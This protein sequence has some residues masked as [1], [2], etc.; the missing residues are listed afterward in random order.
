MGILAPVPIGILM[1]GRRLRWAAVPVPVLA[2][3]VRLGASSS[4]EQ[5]ETWPAERTWRELA[6]AG[7]SSRVLAPAP[8]TPALGREPVALARPARRLPAQ[9]A[10]QRAFHPGRSQQVSG[11][12]RTS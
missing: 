8:A 3:A 7:A 11:E 2:A 6:P 4:M 9:R 5:A 12:A 1:A 10:F